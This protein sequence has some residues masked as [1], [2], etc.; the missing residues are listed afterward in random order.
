MDDVWSLVDRTPGARALVGGLADE[1][2]ERET[3]RVVLAHVLRVGGH[4][5]RTVNQVYELAPG[6]EFMRCVRLCLR[7]W[8]ADARDRVARGEREFATA[9]AALAVGAGQV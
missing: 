8:C 4:D 3:R 6:A 7:V 9:L 2:D 1:V 5:A